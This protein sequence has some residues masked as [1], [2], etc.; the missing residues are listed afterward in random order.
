MADLYTIVT[1]AYA[2]PPFHP[3]LLPHLLKIEFCII[4]TA[5]LSFANMIPV[6]AILVQTHSHDLGMA[7]DKFHFII[8][9]ALLGRAVN[10]ITRTLLWCNSFCMWSINLVKSI[11]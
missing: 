7:A 11:R 3:Q 2:A 6:Q 1:A 5:Y 9:Q 8:L 4:A 10:V